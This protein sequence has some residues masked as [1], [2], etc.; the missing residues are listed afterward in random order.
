MDTVKLNAILSGFSTVY[1]PIS[2]DMH[3]VQ[4]WKGFEIWKGDR[5]SKDYIYTRYTDFGKPVVVSDSGMTVGMFT[6]LV[7]YETPFTSVSAFKA[8]CNENVKDM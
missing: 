3:L 4:N 7:F 1:N 6:R 5:G 8:F 2:V